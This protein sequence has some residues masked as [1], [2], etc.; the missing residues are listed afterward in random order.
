MFCDLELSSGADLG[1]PVVNTV[2]RNVHQELGRFGLND[3]RPGQVEAIEAILGGR[4]LLAVM[5]TGAGKSLCFQLPA[6]V[7]PGLT[8]VVS[9]LIALMKDQV[10]SLRA[11]GIAAAYLA[12]SQTAAERSAT[13]LDVRAGA[14]DLL[15]VSPERLREHT[16]LQLLPRLNVWL[17]AVDEAHCISTWGNDFRPD[18]L[19]IPEAIA[20]LPQ[21]PV[22]AAFTATATPQ[23][24][25][26]IADRLSLDDPERVLAGFDRPNIRFLV[27]FCRSAA[28]RLQD[29]SAELRERPGSGIIY[30]G[31]RKATE[32]QAAW[33]Q[34]D[35]RSAVPYHAGLSPQ[36][37]SD[38][39]E[40][41]QRG[42]IDVICATNAFGMGIDKSDVR[43]VIHTTLPPSLDAY[44]QEA[45]RAGRDGE[46]AD[47]LLMYCRSDRSLQEWLIDQDLP[48]IKDLVFLHEL[49][50]DSGGVLNLDQAALTFDSLT[51]V[52]VGLQVLATAGLIQ[53]GER[54]GGEQAA[55][56]D[57]R[58]IDRRHVVVL[59]QAL[60]RQR[61]W[62]IDQLEEMIAYA[63]GS[64]CRRAAILRYFGDPDAAPRGDAACCDRCARPDSRS[65]GQTSRH[66]GLKNLRTPQRL[67]PQRSA[68]L[69]RIVET[70]SVRA[71]AYDLNLEPMKVADTIRSMIGQGVIE[72]DDLVS[73]EIQSGLQEALQRL[74][75]A[76]IDYRRPRPG[77]L[78]T[79]MRFCPPETNWDDLRFFLAWQRR[80]EALSSLTDE[81]REALDRP[82]R[83]EQHTA[84]KPVALNRGGEKASW[85]ES[86]ELYRDGKSV[87][88]IAE[89]R[90]LKPRTIDGHLVQAVEA[91]NLEL[92][93]LVDENTAAHIQRAIAE[94]P[95]S[96][97]P[98]RD[99]RARAEEIAGRQIPYLA[100]NAVQAQQRLDQ[101]TPDQSENVSSE[102]AELRKRQERAEK[103]RAEYRAA[104]K[105]WPG[106]WEAEY[107]KILDQIAALA[108]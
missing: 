93:A 21:R 102:L 45:G 25:E 89:A 86:L 27:K 37:R 96:E 53:L 78:M 22:V 34:A 52:R 61:S 58:R 1:K 5:P 94:V 15:Y 38:A 39:Q 36:E 83:R 51:A 46:P 98:L 90:G 41:F 79:V 71:T 26:D 81:E 67:S 75:E 95:E 66:A 105:R 12:S 85:M 23:V 48:A 33:L 35:G 31:T 13:L 91:G 60:S 103:L 69:E 16:F 82:A 106:R 55:T 100:I 49:V 84:G 14:I 2:S 9:P 3:F 24:R 68:I 74:D 7:R 20:R 77:Y 108:D 28:I 64:N 6:L 56:T 8:L 65:A 104:G 30:A 42:E 11:Q 47:A 101:S 50:A 57:I 10:D 19:R 63:E 17:V 44:Y 80:Q 92:S 72:I 99:I 54:S 70:G 59:E 107:R 88:E 87:N 40:A 76:G 18:Y 73:P 43:F 29:L 62:R 4:D 97:T 32:E